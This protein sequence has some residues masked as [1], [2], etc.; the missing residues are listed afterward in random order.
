ML[1]P[2]RRGCSPL[3]AEGCSPLTPRPGARS[4]FSYSRGLGVNGTGAA[5]LTRGV[6]RRSW[7]ILAVTPRTL[8]RW[9]RRGCE[10]EAVPPSAGGD[11]ARVRHPHGRD[12]LARPDLRALLRLARAATNR[13]LA[14]TSKPDGHWVSRQARNL[15]I[16]LHDRAASLRETVADARSLLSGRR[17][18]SGDCG[19]ATPSG[20]AALV[21]ERRGAALRFLISQVVSL[22]LQRS[23]VA[24]GSAAG[25]GRAADFLRERRGDRLLW[26]TEG[27]LRH[28]ERGQ[29]NPGGARGPYSTDEILGFDAPPGVAIQIQVA[30]RPA[31]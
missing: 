9:Q 15:L 8:L 16:A 24:V 10:L 14:C 21:P 23:V 5:P 26:R 28:H 27:E 30:F 4:A 1:S 3:A 18:G 11:H 29:R 19:D 20:A 25:L 6:S 2:S 7:A 31:K 22:Q 17:R 12:G 13:I